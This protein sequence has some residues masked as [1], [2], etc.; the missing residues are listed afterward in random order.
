M[1]MAGVVGA[2]NTT[3]VLT[4]R[5]IM[6]DDV[7]NTTGEKVGDIKD[8]MVDV[9]KGC[10]AYA[11]LEYGG[12]LGLGEK[13]FAVP[14]QAFTV[15]EDN[16]RLVLNVAKERLQNAPGF[17]KDHWPMS[18]DANWYDNVDQYYGYGSGM[19]GGATMGRPGY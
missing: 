17:D 2:E 11:V 19:S 4:A 13:L 7:V 5:S 16:K 15:D 1:K 10:I 6:G 9:N 8:L 3:W 18:N 12:F 14:W